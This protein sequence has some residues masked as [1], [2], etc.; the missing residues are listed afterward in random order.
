M[1]NQQQQPSGR[2]QPGDGAPAH[3]SV[4]AARPI[5]TQSGAAAAERA[6]GIGHATENL[7]RFALEFALAALAAEKEPSN[8]WVANMYGA[9]C[10]LIKAA[11]EFRRASLPAEGGLN[12][13]AET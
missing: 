9:R 13:R 8:A 1:D 7:K 12:T 4:E 5:E 3:L 11:F 6:A 2:T 10:R